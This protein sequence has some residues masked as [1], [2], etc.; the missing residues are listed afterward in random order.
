MTK[1]I[2]FEGAVFDM[3]GVITQT[4]KIHAKAWKSIFDDFLKNQAEGRFKP[5]DIKEDY[6]RYIDGKPRLDG[7]RSFLQAR[8]ISLEEGNK[9]DPATSNTVSGLGKRKNDAFL[10]ILEKE[11]VK[12]FPDTLHLLRRW[13]GKL[14]LAVISASKNCQYIMESSG[15]MDY[16]DVRVDGV[17]AEELGLKGKPAP[18]VFLEA[19]RQLRLEPAR[20]LVFEDAIAGVKAG[21][22]GGFGLVV[23]VA[24]EG[25]EAALLENGADFAVTSLEDIEEKITNNV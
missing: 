2:P 25:G 22:K 1:K 10:K 5:F 8:G 19:S 16:F 12:T 13:K 20:C 11:G 15:A 7:I 9:D 6:R 17:I 24:R 14:K 3:D 4:A 18:D 23:G 21:R